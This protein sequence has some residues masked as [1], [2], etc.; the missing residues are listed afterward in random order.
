MTTPYPSPH[1]F[2]A[3]KRQRL[4]DL[5]NEN[6]QQRNILVIGQAAQG[7][8]TLVASYLEAAPEPV[9]WF[10]LSRDDNDQA[11]LFERLVNGITG[12]CRQNRREPEGGGRVPNSILGTEQG[13]QRHLEGLSIVLQ[14]M[15]SPLTIVL[16]DLESMDEMSS[17]FQLINEILSNGFKLLKIFLVSRRMPGF[18]I[19]RLKLDHKVFILNNDDLAFT[20]DET[21]LFFAG[22]KRVSSGDIEKI[23]HITDGWAGGLTLVSES[24]RRFKRMN[25]L[26]DRLSSEVFDFFSQEIYQ[27]LPDRISQ[28][29]IQT[30]VLDTID[31]EIVDR[32][33]E[34]GHG[35]EIL[36]ELER[37]NLFVQRI[38]S[39]TGRPKFKY[40]NLFREFLLQDLLKTSG[41]SA[42]KSLNQKI[43]QFFWEKKDHEQA[44]NYFLEAKAFPDIVRIIK[45][46][47]TDYIISGKLS[48]LEKWISRLPEDTIQNDPWLIFLS[49]MTQRIKGGKKN[50]RRLETAFSL[51]EQIPDI[52]GMLLSAGYLIE[53]AVF[54]RQPSPMILEWNQKGEALLQKISGKKQYAWARALLWQQI[55]LGYIA[56]DG[57]IPKGVSACRNAVLL[58]RHINN[59]DLVLNASITMTFGYVQAGDFVNA[60]QMLSKIKHMTGEGRNPEYRALK[61]MVDIDFALKNGRFDEAGECLARSEADIEKF[62]LIFLYPGFVEAKAL[63]QIYT[64]QFDEARQ[65]ADHLNDFSIL[66]GNDFYRGIS[67]RIKALSFLQE[68]RFTSASREIQKALKEL[69]Q[70]RKGDIHHFLAKQMEGLISFSNNNPDEARRSLVSALG[71]F[72]SI[73][74]D[75]SCAETCFALGLLFWETKDTQQAMHYL[76]RAFEKSFAGAYLFF[77]LISRE[78]LIQCAFLLVIYHEIRPFESYV[79]SLLD[80]CDPKQVREQIDWILARTEKAQTERVIEILR[81]YYKR[82]LPGIRIETLGK[83]NIFCGN[84][85]LDKKA[86][87]GS[88]PLL[89]L[90]S[91]VLHGSRDI[92]KEILIDDIWPDATAKAGDKNFKINLHRLRKAIEPSPKKEFGYSYILHRAGLISLDPQ[93]V[94]VDADE[95][96]AFGARAMAL[97]R[98]NRP[99]TALEFY[100]RAVGMYKGDYFCEEPYMEWISR[101]RDLFRIKFMELVQKKAMLH[102]DLDE[103]DRAIETWNFILSVDPCFE[104]AYQNLMILH[105]D[106]GR[107]KKALDTFEQCRRVLEKEMGSG[108]DKETLFIYEQIKSR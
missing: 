59:S 95:F 81:P 37:R 42:Y 3:V 36:V 22:D 73:A 86:F 27:T 85:I 52:R 13:L 55:G 58:G 49:T 91:I 44:M 94:V 72:E 97:E 47:G 82:L 88:R 48:G 15:S 60:R 65:T 6:Y 12:I 107:Q 89:L 106:T 33:F 79:L 105:A 14:S 83:F 67:H 103:I 29:L 50:I 46:K 4:F 93:L 90:K 80:L 66:E 28:F 62:G 53:A 18:N 99:D 43:G 101:K 63:H 87:E 54:I 92:P 11:L 108:P 16:D 5:L 98:D 30:S 51:F 24:L 102:E 1:I 2:D 76:N 40:H 34:P 71:Y 77:P 20:L 104:T 41:S 17:G 32:L 100:T 26:P 70:A 78:T 69:D 57:N 39:D 25:H 74:S 21:R 45:I 75:L 31:L 10:Q 64:G 84:K 9:L 61:S 35:L 96:I 56:G 19:P 68:K 38:D 23:H 8:T 7:K